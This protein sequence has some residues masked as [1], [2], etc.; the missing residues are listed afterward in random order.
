[1]FLLVLTR[2]TA[3][4]RKKLVD[5]S[6]DCGANSVSSVVSSQ[7]RPVRNPQHELPVKMKQVSECF[8]TVNILIYYLTVFFLAVT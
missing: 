3:K 5:G 8:S 6:S 2:K 7:L 1:M 4:S